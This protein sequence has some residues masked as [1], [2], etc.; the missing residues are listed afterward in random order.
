MNL[1]LDPVFIFGFHWGMTG[2]AV[3]TVKKGRPTRKLKKRVMSL[4]APVPTATRRSQSLGRW[5]RSSPTVASSKSVW[6]RTRI[7]DFTP[8]SVRTSRQRLPAIS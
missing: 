8:A 3:A 6:V 7:S 2:A 4:M 5:M 1:A